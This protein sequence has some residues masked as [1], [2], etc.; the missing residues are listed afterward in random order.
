MSAAFDKI[1]SLIDQQ[2]S[3]VLEAG[4]GSGKTFTLI[5]TLNH[6]I[7][8]RGAELKFRNKK[9]A[10]IT[11]TNV[12]K[13]EIIDRIEN[14]S[15]VSVSTIHEFLWA[16]L[17]NYQ[18]QL[19]IE[20]DAL[21]TLRYHEAPDKYQPNLLQRGNVKEV[22]YADS[23][24]RDF[25]TG[26]LHHDDVII[27][28]AEMLKKY[29]LLRKIFAEKY[30]YIFID[31]YQDTAIETVDAFV[32]ALLPEHSAMLLLGFFGDSYQKIYDS[33]IGSLDEYVQQNK[34][35]LVPKEEN[36]RSSTCVINLL[37]K[38]RDNITQVAPDGK[39]MNLGSVSF[40][41]CDNYQAQGKM[42]IMEYEKSILPQ[43]NTNYDAVVKKLEEKGWTFQEGSKDKVLIIANSRVAE[44]GGF[45]ELYKLFS[46][47]YGEGANDMLLKRENNLVRFFAGSVDRKSSKERKSGV[48]HLMLYWAE[49]D[50]SNV[51]AFLNT[52]SGL[53]KQVAQGHGNYFLLQRH[54]DKERIAN[55]LE[56]LTQLRENGTVKDVFDFC[57]AN[58]IVRIQDSLAKYLN[59]LETPLP[60]DAEEKA[61]ERLSKDIALIHGMMNLPY[62]QV[63]RFFRFTQSQTVFSTKHGTKG[64][65]FRNVLVVIDD[66]SWKQKYNFEN[67]INDQEAN[68]D[69]KLRTRNLFYV[70][71][72]RAIENLVILSLSQMEQGAMTVIYDWFTANRLFSINDISNI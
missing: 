68:A 16:N 35:V 61:K 17:A 6:I 19:L 55:T 29:P 21:N 10:C 54:S 28:A 72:S 41:N 60:D 8:T 69:R 11:Y 12:A 65:E 57:I 39:E 42:K 23:G 32:N 52:Y 26:Q 25:E 70:S 24:F 27:L 38:I 2:R 15:M 5:E 18:K 63:W 49:K 37:N 1:T 47:R 31:E 40:I 59:R 7:L 45:G 43:K 34:L 30:P 33:G 66:T 3:F 58:N 48:E 46:T 4:A 22:I 44:R 50:F 20:L 67:F 53:S 14:N 36:Y 13:N 56:E 64:D 51:I 71:C 9:I 62:E